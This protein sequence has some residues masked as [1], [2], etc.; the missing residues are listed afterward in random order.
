MNIGTQIF[1][2]KNNDIKKFYMFDD[3]SVRDMSH[4]IGSIIDYYDF[5]D[6]YNNFIKDGYIEI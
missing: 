4:G 2:I 3:G 5:I 1:L 6:L